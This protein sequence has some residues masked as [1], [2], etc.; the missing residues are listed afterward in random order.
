MA[1]ELQNWSRQTNAANAGKTSGGEGGPAMFTFQSSTDNVAT[2]SAAGYFI[3]AQFELSVGD[4][5][6]VNASDSFTSLRVAT[7]DRTAGTITTESVSVTDPVGTANIEDEAVT[8]DKLAE[9]VE[10]S[11]I[12]K[13]A[14]SATTAG[15]AAAEDIAVAGA[16]VTDLAFVQVSDDGTNNV[17]VLSAIAAADKITVTYSGNPGADLDISYQLLRATA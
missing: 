6:F 2:I 1:F 12:V 11:H 8:L 3:P 15:G 5:I 4:L 10:P 17:T 16:L 14:G 9:I 13:F 7:N